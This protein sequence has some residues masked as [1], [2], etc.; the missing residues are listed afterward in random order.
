MGQRGAV[1]VGVG[2]GALVLAV[3]GW[4]GADQ[5]PARADGYTAGSAGVGDRLFPLAGNGGYRVDRYQLDLG[6]EPARRLL[7][8]TARITAT[9]CA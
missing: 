1:R 3:L 6:Y 4:T 2:T 7:T 8:G 9:A 5:S